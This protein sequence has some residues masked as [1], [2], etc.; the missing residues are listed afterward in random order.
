MK[1]GIRRCVIPGNWCLTEKSRT[2]E[3]AA[4]TVLL[5]SSLEAFLSVRLSFSVTTL[6]FCCGLSK[7]GILF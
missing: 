3:V 7:F 1:V 5:H 2:Q 6:T 4:V